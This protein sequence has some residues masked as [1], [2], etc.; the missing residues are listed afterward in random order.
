MKY[1]VEKPFCAMMLIFLATL[2][3]FGCT[4]KQVPVKKNSDDFQI[5]SDTTVMLKCDAGKYM[6]KVVT[7]FLPNIKDTACIL[8]QDVLVISTEGVQSAIKFP[9][10]SFDVILGKETKVIQETFISG[11][12]CMMSPSGNCAFYFYGISAFD[13]KH[14]FFGI[15]LPEGKWACYYLGNSK[16]V[17]KQ[18]G[19][20]ELYDQEYGDEMLNLDG[21][22]S[23][24]EPNW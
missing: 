9:F 24:F 20:F 22:T 13:P 17:I 12:K 16:E 15:F 4:G 21:M 1:T 18:Y 19:D 23:V 11:V 2:Y 8:K 5:Q 10:S 14:E 6:I 3:T 7:R